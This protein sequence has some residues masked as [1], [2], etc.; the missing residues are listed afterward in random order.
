MQMQGL[1]AWKVWWTEKGE[2][3]RLCKS[4]PLILEVVQVDI[5][6]S[7]LQVNS[8]SFFFK[9]KGANEIVNEK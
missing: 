8:Q 9:V 1:L 2:S 6:Y 5:V 4:L 3:S 7:F